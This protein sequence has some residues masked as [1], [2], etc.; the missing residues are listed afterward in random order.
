[1]LYIKYLKTPGI[2]QLKK[3]ATLPLFFTQN[4]LKMSS[5]IDEQKIKQQSLHGTR[6]IMMPLLVSETVKIPITVIYIRINS[7]EN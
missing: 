4:F 6:W 1:M 3:N 2:V 5:L 7:E